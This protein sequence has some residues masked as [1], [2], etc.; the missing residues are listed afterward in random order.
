M[1]SRV[2]K[3]K[4]VFNVFSV[5]EVRGVV[6]IE[7]ETSTKL[8]TPFFNPIILTILITE[9]SSVLS[10]WN[11]VFQSYCLRVIFIGYG[12]C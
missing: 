1:W 7:I 12:L 8:Y 10:V 2:E 3:I 11:C 4:H 5:Q 6:V 9:P